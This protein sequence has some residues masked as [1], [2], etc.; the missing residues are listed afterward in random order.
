[1]NTFKNTDKF[2][3][4]SELKSNTVVNISVKILSKKQREYT[5]KAGTKSTY[6]IGVLEDESS[7]ISYKVW[8]TPKID[9]DANF[10]EGRSVLVYNAMVKEWNSK[11]EIN[12][13]NNTIIKKGED[14]VQSTKKKIKYGSIGE[15][16]GKETTVNIKAGI[17]KYNIIETYK[18]PGQPSKLY[19]AKL[20][21]NTGSI[22]LMSFKEQ[23]TLK[24]G[25][26]VGIINATVSVRS[27]NDSKTLRLIVNDYTD[28]FIIDSIHEETTTLPQIND[29]FDKVAM[30][31]S[32]KILADVINVERIIAKLSCSICKRYVSAD[33]RC[34]EHPDAG[35]NIEKYIKCIIDDNTASARTYIPVSFVTSDEHL[36][37]DD[38]ISIG[39]MKLLFRKIR[40]NGKVKISDYGIDIYT[41]GEKD[42]ELIDESA[43]FTQHIKKMESLLND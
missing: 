4:L 42:V 14:I 5:N 34:A 27:F 1:M 37:D 36:T 19:I 7:T 31:S 16:S 9:L 24:E 29:I 28:I 43:Y 32:L 38:I 12:L 35:I 21:D 10:D 13:N 18:N 25:N 6:F 17:S 40:I 8:G 20:E 26:K 41:A 39:Q 15:I 2:T 23:N 30:P 22:D 3:K 11:L 33:K